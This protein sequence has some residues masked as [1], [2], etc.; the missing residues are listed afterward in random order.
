MNGINRRKMTWRVSLGLVSLTLCLLLIAEVAGLMPDRFDVKLKE[1]QKVVELLAVQVASAA[2]RDDV[3]LT[4]TLLATMVERDENTVS[5]GLRRHD[6][7]LAVAGDHSRQWIPPEGD[8]STSTHVQVPIVSDRGEWG[9]LEIV[10]SPLHP[11]VGFTS[12]R[13]SSLAVLSF[14]G[15]IGFI[16]YFLYLRRVL[17]ELDPSTVVPEHV[18]SAFDALAE[19]VLIIDKQDR[20]VLANSEFAKLIGCKPNELVGRKASTL[21]WQVEDSEKHCFPWQRALEAGETAI[22]VSLI[23]EGDSDNPRHFNVNG[24]PVLDAKGNSRGALATF[25]D[26]TEIERKNDALEDALAQLNESQ[27]ALKSKKRGA[28]TS[29]YA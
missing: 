1:R 26:L 3:Q 7:L 17:R 11:A 9:V 10:F 24:A 14:I 28:G 5:A 19:G 13:D 16:L 8:D 22:G 6:R 18:R 23:W 29:G 4:R 20:I 27:I 12:W 25:D 2:A 15:I 21:D